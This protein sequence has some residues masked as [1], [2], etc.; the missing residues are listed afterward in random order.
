MNRWM[1][2]FVAI[3]APLLFFGLAAAFSGTDDPPAGWDGF[4]DGVTLAER[5]AIGDILARPD[6]FEGR[7]VAVEGEII[8]V[9]KMMGCWIEL[10]SGEGLRLRVKVDDGVIVFPESALGKRSIAQG[11]VESLE[12]TREE[13]VER[14]RHEAEEMGREFD[15][16]S[17]TPP[18]REIR[19]RGTG[20]WI[21]S[22]NN[23]R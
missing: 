2:S 1:K 4:G 16:D 20:A 8:G 15:P 7:T 23:P 9:C 19:L 17:V 22:G 12:F 5:T 13:A 21:E 6:E 10:Q 18:Y 14:A 3:L 11:E